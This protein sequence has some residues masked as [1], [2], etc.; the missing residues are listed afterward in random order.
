MW[1]DNI[2]KQIYQHINKHTEPTNLCVSSGVLLNG[3]FWCKPYCSHQSHIYG[4]FSFW[5]RV[6]LTSGGAVCCQYWR[7][8]WN[9][10]RRKGIN[11]RII[12]LRP[13]LCMTIHSTQS[14]SRYLVGSWFILTRGTTYAQTCIFKKY[15]FSNMLLKNIVLTDCNAQKKTE[16]FANYISTF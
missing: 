15:R 6:T 12:R 11:K 1:A 9:C 2:I 16:E 8:T 3:S 10:N 5:N 7:G 14:M 4:F 13:W